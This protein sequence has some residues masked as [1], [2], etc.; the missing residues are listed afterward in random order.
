MVQ[1][2]FYA[3]AR[4]NFQKLIQFTKISVK[5]YLILVSLEELNLEVW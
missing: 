5:K 2:R 4:A 3:K 1:L